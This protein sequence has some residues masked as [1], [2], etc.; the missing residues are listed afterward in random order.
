MNDPNNSR[1]QPGNGRK[2]L[3]LMAAVFFGPL[4]VAAW[5][6]FNDANLA[7]D[8][9]TNHG[10]LLEPIT[11]LKEQLPESPLPT[12]NWLLLYANAGECASDC[13][14]SLHTVRQLRLMLGKEMDRVVRIWLHGE[15]P[16]DTV[17]VNEEH[18]GLLL[19]E[20]RALGELLAAK[21]P[22][23]LKTGGYFLVDPNA[24]LVMYFAPD[25]DPRDMVTDI[26]RLLRL[27]H[28]G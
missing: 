4:L 26:K 6:Y 28:I 16:P 15:T 14:D 12:G 27:S 23:A 22:A 17:F 20:D 3:M 13:R 9:R 2:T 7:P 18:P 8:G 24:N 19:V 11:N 10:V 5:M 25:L 1:P 21:K